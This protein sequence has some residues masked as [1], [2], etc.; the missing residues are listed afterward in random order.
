[1]NKPTVLFAAQD[2]NLKKSINSMLRFQKL[3]IIES[4]SF[5]DTLALYE[6]IRPHLLI[7]ESPR[8]D[9]IDALSLA[10]YIRGWDRRFP[11]IL[12][13]LQGTKGLV[14]SALRAGLKDYFEFPFSSKEFT[15]SV[16]RCISARSLSSIGSTG[17]ESTNNR[18]LIGS[19]T[20][21]TKLN[22]FL[23][24]VASVDSNVLIT[25]ET[26]TGKE[27]TAQIIHT[28]S[29]R[30]H[31]PFITINCAALPD[32][33]LESEL[34]G[35]EK[36]AFTGAQNAYLGKLKLAD[37]GTVFLDEI[38]DMSCYAQAKILR[39]LESKEVYPLGGK[40]SI[41]LDIRIIAATNRNL[42]GLI[43]QKEFREDLY[44]RLNVARLRLPP[45]RERKEDIPEL[46]DYYLKYFNELFGKKLL[47]FEIEALSALLDYHWPGN[48][49]ELKNTLESIFIDS[50]VERIA[51]EDLPESIR[52]N[53]TSDDFSDSSERERLLEALCSAN[54]N[55]SKA[56]EQ[57]QWSRMTLYR[58]MEK[59][60][61]SGDEAAFIN[62]LQSDRKM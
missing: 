27:I 15:E 5:Q 39:V 62:S 53:V 59:Y 13:T 8:L 50:P 55:K 40:R 16:K 58:K 3:D 20:A 38:G 17:S 1:M 35:Y 29:L 44:F 33:L 61:I 60:N 6:A 28:Q 51:I 45:L 56:A 41:P 30:A 57:L 47:G 37:G 7:L 34:F 43:R 42:E 9:G 19:S 11:I 2:L 26:G 54:W 4:G 24:K 21:M 48:V 14:I 23:P 52:G 10:E 36:G 32:G 31:K 18:K 49:R 46:L 25:G 22:T 12:V